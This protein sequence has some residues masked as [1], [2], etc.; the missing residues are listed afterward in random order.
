MP[1]VSNVLVIGAGA[2]GAGGVSGELRD[3][4][5][6]AAGGGTAGLITG[7]AIPVEGGHMAW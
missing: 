1:A 3:A 5:P 4:A 7:A 6:H 2:A